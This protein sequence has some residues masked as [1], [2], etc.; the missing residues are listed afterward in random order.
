[1]DD[2]NIDYDVF[3]DFDGSLDGFSL[4]CGGSPTSSYD[5]G[6]DGTASGSIKLWSTGGDG[7]ACMNKAVPDGVETGFTFYFW[8]KG[9]SRFTIWNGYTLER[10]TTR[11]KTGET[12]TGFAGALYTEFNSGDPFDDWELFKVVL[13]DEDL[14]STTKLYFYNNSTIG[15]AGASWYDFITIRDH[16]EA[17]FIT[18]SVDMQIEPELVY[19]DKVGDYTPTHNTKK[20]LPFTPTQN[21]KKKLRPYLPTHPT[22]K[23]LY[24]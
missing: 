19:T 2:Y 13:I 21:I 12:I 10:T 6:F 11:V 20:K 24:D 7:L 4:G 1:M 23:K 5:T 16:N 8:S 15:E 9:Y 18:E 17:L 14:A 3:A 22:R